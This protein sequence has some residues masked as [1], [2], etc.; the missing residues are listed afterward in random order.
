MSLNLAHETVYVTVNDDESYTMI[1]AEMP[2]VQHLADLAG[3][4]GPLRVY[5]ADIIISDAELVFTVNAK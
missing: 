2:D 3:C 4:A 5:A 1:T